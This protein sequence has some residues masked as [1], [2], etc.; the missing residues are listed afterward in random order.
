MGGG[1]KKS[2]KMRAFALSAIVVL[3]LSVRG[4]NLCAGDTCKACLGSSASE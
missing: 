1:V 2:G 4:A 3:F